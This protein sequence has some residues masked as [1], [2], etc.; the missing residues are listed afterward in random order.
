M[1]DPYLVATGKGLEPFSASP[2]TKSL[3]EGF[4]HVDGLRVESVS[5]VKAPRSRTGKLATR[6]PLK[7][8]TKTPPSGPLTGVGTLADKVQAKR[9]EIMTNVE[10]D[11][12]SGGPVPPVSKPAAQ[13]IPIFDDDGAEDLD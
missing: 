5:P 7:E 6:T 1:Q 12:S 10:V 8:A 2:G 13:Y 4:P 11:G 9:D 3:Q